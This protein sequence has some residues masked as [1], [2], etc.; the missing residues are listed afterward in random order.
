MRVYQQGQADGLCGLY[1][2]IHFLN[3][4]I[5]WRE[6]PHKALWYL[7]ESCRHLGWLTPHYLTEGFEDYQLKAI[8]DL[9]IANYRLGFTTYYVADLLNSAASKSYRE[10]LDRVVTAGGSAIVTRGKADHWVLV[11][12]G[13][14]GPELFDSSNYENPRSA[15]PD[16]LSD[17]GWG[18]AI[19]PSERAQITADL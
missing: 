13:P 2:L 9:Q 1:A 5:E 6:K 8:L 12:Q 4:Q 14:D 19:L 11:T 18:I 16:R 7:L 17:D 10:L 15:L 3:Q